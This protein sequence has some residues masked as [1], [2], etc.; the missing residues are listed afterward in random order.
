[1]TVWLDGLT[2][3]IDRS[4][5]I[6]CSIIA[7]IWGQMII[8]GVFKKIFKDR[9]TGA[10]YFSL[11]MAGWVIPVSLMAV[12]LFLNAVSLGQ[13]GMFFLLGI[14]I[15]AMLYSVFSEKLVQG[16]LS[17]CYVMLLFVVIS[18]FLH[19]AFLQKVIFPLYFD[20]AE[21]YRIIK[22]FLSH[23]DHSSRSGFLQWP[24]ANY[25]HVGYHFLS[26]AFSYVSHATIVENM[27]VHGQIVLAILPISL[28]FII[29]QE[30]GSDVPALFTCLLA[31][32]GWHM[33]GYAVNWGKYPAL[34]SL[35][36][37]HLVLSIGYLLYRNNKFKSER[38]KLYLI[39][40]IGVLVSGFVH[41]RSLI[42][43]TVLALSMLLAS[44][45]KRLPA[46]YR[47]LSF[48][49]VICALI[50]EV[51]YTRTN[52]ILEPLLNIYLHN[53]FLMAGL[54]LLLVIFSMPVFMDATFFIFIVLSLLLFGLFIPVNGLLPGYGNLVLLDRPYIQ[55][56][57]YLPLSILGGLGLAG[58]HLFLQKFS[59]FSIRLPQLTMIA[60][61]GFV[62][63]NAFHNYGFYPSTC[64][65][66]VGRD[67][68]V[69]FDWMDKTLPLNAN[70][71]IAST[72]LYV[73]SLE[74]SDSQVGVDGGI[75]LTPLI[76]R[77][78]VLMSGET[79]F[80]QPE[81]WDQICRRNLDYIYVGGMSQSF[82]DILLTEHA[83][84]YQ[85]VFSLPHTK[86]YQVIGCN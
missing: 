4:W 21:H 47:Y 85:V 81:T 48:A 12:L 32:F 71:L 56:L 6:V 38:S 66:I 41:T 51:S 73:T 49:F 28:F 64:C 84:W 18:I 26:A 61:F 33:P 83:D 40:G 57:L 8:T 42:V 29:R 60:L 25:Y 15:L 80:G 20:S 62:I 86:V 34:F 55:M 72:R 59:Y 31:G 79:D 77:K 13:S 46:P 82:K 16:S 5:T 52:S 45:W 70:I 19:L 74:R 63:F 65:Q 36:C 9:L 69:A 11:G 14:A 24:S 17:V 1:M 44:W 2:V 10:E 76:S 22:Y 50:I 75:W 68:L 78:M 35:I 37:T 67:D 39:L 43:Y 54:I 58:L 23:Y 7:I 30:T 27:L 3:L 53:D